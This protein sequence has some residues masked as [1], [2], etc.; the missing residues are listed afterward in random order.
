MK[1]EERHYMRLFKAIKYENGQPDKMSSNF[2]TDSKNETWKCMIENGLSHVSNGG[3]KADKDYWIS[4]TK[5]LRDAYEIMNENDLD[6]IAIIDL[7]NTNLTGYIYDKTL[8]EK[9]FLETGSTDGSRKSNFLH[10]EDGIIVTLDMTSPF[11]MSYL[12]SYLWLKGNTESIGNIRAIAYAGAKSEVLVMG[13]NIEFYYLSKAQIDTVTK[14]N[15]DFLDD[16]EVVIPD[17]YFNLFS[18]FAKGAPDSLKRSELLSKFNLHDQN[19]KYNVNGSDGDFDHKTSFNKN[20]Q[21]VDNYVNHFYDNAKFSFCDNE[22]ENILTRYKDISFYDYLYAYINSNAYRYYKMHTMTSK[23]ED[24]AYCWKWL[25]E[26]YN[27]QIIPR[28]IEYND[29]LC[30]CNHSLGAFSEPV[31]FKISE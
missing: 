12:A 29:F 22:H 13:V 7:P 20:Y 6:G 24:I 11:T 19:E 26:I 18:A 15:S 30:S 5:S 8:R 3:Q 28:C 1:K 9:G 14:S 17:Y 16:S 10:N 27:Y 2:S 21:L 25:N 31:L 23:R 4:T